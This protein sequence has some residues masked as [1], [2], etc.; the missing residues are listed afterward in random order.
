MTANKVV[1]FGTTLPVTAKAFLLPLLRELA[2]RGWDVH[3]VTS[4]GPGTEDLAQLPFMTTDPVPKKPK[5]SPIQDIRS[6]EKMIQ[7]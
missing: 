6:L 3:L 1:V 4:P 7:G 5:I 2:Q